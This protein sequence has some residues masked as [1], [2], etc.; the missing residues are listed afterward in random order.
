M[1]FMKSEKK[2]LTQPTKYCLTF[3][4]E[5][6]FLILTKVDKKKIRKLFYL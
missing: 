1:N 5:G 3:H 6:K 2:P 4:C